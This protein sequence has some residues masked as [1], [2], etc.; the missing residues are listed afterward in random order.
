MRGGVRRSSGFSPSYRRRDAFRKEEKKRGSCTG[1]ERKKLGLSGLV[2]HG[3][4]KEASLMRTGEEG[5][6]QKLRGK[7]QAKVFVSGKPSVSR[8]RGE[9]RKGK[10]MLRDVPQEGEKKP[11][12]CLESICAER[13]APSGE[14]QEG[15]TLLRLSEKKR[16]NSQHLR[17]G[18]ILGQLLFWGEKKEANSR[19]LICCKKGK[20]TFYLS[21]R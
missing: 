8:Q 12:N 21:S 10:K 9:S 14:G 19:P 11:R 1:K 13:S 2:Q 7:N 4:R 3:N 15:G 20:T 5:S 6:F 17:R 18:R 16:E